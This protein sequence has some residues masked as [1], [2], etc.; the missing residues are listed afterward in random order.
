MS[1]R[2]YL[3]GDRKAKATTK[4]RSST[5]HKRPPV[6]EVHNSTRSSLLSSVLFKHP[7]PTGFLNQVRLPQAMAHPSNLILS[8][9]PMLFKPQTATRQLLSSIP[10]SHNQTKFKQPTTM[11]H[12]SS[13]PASQV[14]NRPL[15]ITADPEITQFN[16]QSDFL[17]K[18][19]CLLLFDHR[20]TTL[21]RNLVPLN[22]TR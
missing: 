11:D 14:P 6:T 18:E 15:P 7:T 19:Q 1:P 4:L 16:Q 8:R 12:L 10:F 3:R 17:S 22:Q 5:R 20:T 21:D 9:C 13:V 2:A